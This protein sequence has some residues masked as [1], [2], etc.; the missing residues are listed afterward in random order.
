MVEENVFLW[1]DVLESDEGAIFS[2]RWWVVVA[3]GFTVLGC[4]LFGVGIRSG[5]VG[6]EEGVLVFVEVLSSFSSSSRCCFLA[7]CTGWLDE[8]SLS[9]LTT[10]CHSVLQSVVRRQCCLQ[11]L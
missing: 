7:S 1:A 4:L 8:L 5:V 10:D 9:L 3:E 11:C 6:L 2:G